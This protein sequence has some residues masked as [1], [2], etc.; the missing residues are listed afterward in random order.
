MQNPGRTLRTA[1]I[2]FVATAA[3]ALLADY[4]AR[5]GGNGAEARVQPA[6]NT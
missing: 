3:A 1:L 2:T 5:R 4:L 6:R